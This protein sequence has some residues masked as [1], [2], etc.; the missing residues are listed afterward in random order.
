MLQDAIKSRLK[1]GPTVKQ[2]N[3]DTPRIGD[4]TQELVH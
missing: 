2:H 4:E 1:T 3:E